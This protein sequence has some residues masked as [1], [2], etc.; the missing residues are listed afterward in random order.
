MLQCDNIGSTI[1]MR[2]MS[3][4]KKEIKYV[5]YALIVVLTIIN[6]Y[7]ITTKPKEEVKS[8]PLQYY[9]QIVSI[10]VENGQKIIRV[11]G[12]STPYTQYDNNLEGEVELIANDNIDI[13]MRVGPSNNNTKLNLGDLRKMYENLEE[14]DCIAFKYKDLVF[15]NRK[16]IEEIIFTGN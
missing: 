15:E 11:K 3:D 2:G 14:G 1:F 16:E 5:I 8:N 7:F 6:I 10:K 4:M 9:G 13:R 12:A